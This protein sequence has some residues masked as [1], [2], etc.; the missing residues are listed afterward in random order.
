MYYEYTRREP[1]RYCSLFTTLHG[2]SIPPALLHR[3]AIVSQ[4]NLPSQVHHPYS[5]D[6]QPYV[7]GAA[8]YCPVPITIVGLGRLQE[9]I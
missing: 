3:P 8:V 7:S 1:A 2:L 9:M 4:N 5:H 6:L